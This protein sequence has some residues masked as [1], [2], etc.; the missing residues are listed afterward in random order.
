MRYYRYATVTLSEDDSSDP[1]QIRFSDINRT[2]KS[3]TTIV[4]SSSGTHSL[5]AGDTFLLPMGQITLGKYLYL[6]SDAEFEISINGADALTMAPDV[7]N[8]LWAEFTTLSVTAPSDGEGIRLTW[9][10]GGD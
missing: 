2:T 8:E 1:K 7:V 10:I 6:L 4:D 3:T 9:A 5:A